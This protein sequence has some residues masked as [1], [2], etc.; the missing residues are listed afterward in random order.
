MSNIIKKATAIILSFLLCFQGSIIQSLAAV[1]TNA[2]EIDES[3]LEVDKTD[4]TVGDVVKISI[5]ATDETGIKDA[6]MF[7]RMPISGKWTIINL[8]YNE[9]TDRYEGS[10]EVNDKSESGVWKIEYFYFEDSNGYGKKIYNDELY[11]YRDSK[12]LSKGDFSVSGTTVDTNAPEIDESTLE[13]DKKDVTVGDVV[14]ISIK[15]TDDTGIKEAYMF[16]RMPISGNLKFINLNY[17]EETD[18]YEA[19]Y[20]VNDKSESGVWKIEYFYFEDS[21]GYGKKIYNDELYNYRDSKDL[22]KGDFNVYDERYIGISPL[23]NVTYYKENVTINNKTIQ[24]DVYIGPEAVVTFNNVTVN[25]NIYVLGALKANSINAKAI[26]GREMYYGYVSS[27]HKGTIILS[28]SNSINSII[29]TTYPV[30]DIPVRI[31]DNPINVVDGYLNIKGVIPDVVDLYVNNTKIDTSTQGK[32]IIDDLYVGNVDKIT[33]SFRTVFGNTI[34]KTFDVD[35]CTKL[36][37]GSINSIPKI[38]VEDLIFKV[39]DEI[40]PLE[41]VKAT[42]KEDGDI[43]SNIKIIE[44][45]VD[46]TKAGEYKVVYEVQDSDGNKVTKEIKVT[47]NPR[48]SIINSIPTIKAEDVLLKVGD[49]FDAMSEVSASD[50]EDGD[51]TSKIKVIENT[52]DTTKVG[53]YKVV[54]KVTDSQGASVSK[55]IKVVVRSNEKPEIKAEDVVLKVGDKFDAMSGVSASD[56]EDGDI[57]SN[58]KIIENTVDTTKAGKYKVV[59]EV[60]DKDGNKVRKEINVTVNPI[61]ISKM[62]VILSKD[63]VIYDGNNQEPNVSINGLSKEDYTVSY[64]NNIDVGMATITIEGKGNYTGTITKTFTIRPA[65]VVNVKS[66]SNSYSSNKV[67]WSPAEK[68][69]GYEVY[70]AT[71]ESGTYYLRTT[72]S[73]TSYTNTALT[74]GKT[75]YY[76]VRAYKIVDGEKLYGDFSEIVSSKP[77][78]SSTTA[79]VSSASYNSNKVTW[80]SVSGASGYEVYRATSNGGTYSLRTTRSTTSYTNTELTTGKTYYYKV[81]PY[82][83]VDGKKVYGDFSVVVSSSP[84]LTTPSVTLSAGYKKATVKWNKISGASGY[85]IYRSSSKSGTYSRVKSVTSGSTTSYTNS[86]LTSRKGYYYKIKA[87]RT[88]D[89]KKVYSSYSSIKYIKVK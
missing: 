81:R 26:K 22:S 46:T 36:P 56:K 61:D 87:Y 50:K 86:G 14:K 39:G 34:E 15:A 83:L 12:D 19:S 29:C 60:E 78:L 70:R 24:G 59:Y 6:Y 16:Y 53:E 74:T 73:T 10:Y 47:V 69:D 67:T 54:Y 68:V 41:Y 64:K 37:D 5:K 40:N 13:V 42:D 52:V 85:E 28:G 72:R 31:D 51:I 11:N 18:R 38:Q 71:S 79:K 45:T 2:P 57:T 75:Y 66:T 63:S 25:G 89:G 55:T 27:Y 82:R 88:V 4:V 30:T 9:E 58:I 3:T 80:N 8:N 65:S 1:D 49:K 62:D 77:Q 17:N 84:K 48:L 23:E 76:K 35:Q 43:T 33:L 7:Y 32:F 44:N 20:E 21:N